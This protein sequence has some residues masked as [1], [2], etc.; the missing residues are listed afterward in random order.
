[1]KKVSQQLPF[2]GSESVLSCSISLGPPTIGGFLP[3]AQ[4]QQKKSRSQ[5]EGKR[6]GIQW[7]ILAKGY[8]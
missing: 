8:K 5:K 3:L 7:K 1:M 6:H 4:L 2:Y